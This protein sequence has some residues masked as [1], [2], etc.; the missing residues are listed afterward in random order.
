MSL[1]SDREWAEEHGH[2][3]DYDDDEREWQEF[4]TELDTDAVPPALC[5]GEEED[6]Q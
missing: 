6:N 4:E 3:D 1:Q 2:L 5:D